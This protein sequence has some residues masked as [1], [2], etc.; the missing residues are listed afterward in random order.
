MAADNDPI[1]VRVAGANARLNGIAP[2]QMRCVVSA[3]FAGREVRRIGPYDMILAN[4][5][6]GPLRRMASDL[7]PHL[8]ANGWLILSGILNEQAVGVERAYA[9]RGLRCWAML[10]IGD[11]TT[12]VM[13]PAA[14]GAMPRLWHGRQ[15]AAM[16]SEEE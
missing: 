1:A 9:A 3:G 2:Q 12:I 8:A 15:P 10:R 6:A 5:L 4:I 16:V 13:R 7:V 14:I 11:W